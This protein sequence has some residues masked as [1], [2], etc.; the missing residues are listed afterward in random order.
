[1]K[2]YLILVRGGNPGFE[3]LD[4]EA[5]GALY[6]KWGAYMGKLIES[7]NWVNGAPSTT[8]VDSFAKRRNWWKVLSEKMT[9]RSVA[10]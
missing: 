9:Y 4:Q 7:E 6:Q 5:Q 3:N 2:S 10:T 8:A 1:M